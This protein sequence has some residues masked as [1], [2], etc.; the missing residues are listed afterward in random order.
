MIQIRVAIE[1]LITVPDG[2]VMPESGGRALILPSGD[3]VK[4]FVVFELNDERDLTSIEAFEMG[5][6]IDEEIVDW[7]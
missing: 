2:T 3:W 5:L 6:D 7:F 1:A 4:P